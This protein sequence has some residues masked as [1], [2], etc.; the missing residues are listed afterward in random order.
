MGSVNGA[1]AFGGVVRTNL[2]PV[3]LTSNARRK[4]PETDEFANRTNMRVTLRHVPL[5]YRVSVN[6]DVE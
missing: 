3:G 5:I 1:Q 6:T 4:I 2:D